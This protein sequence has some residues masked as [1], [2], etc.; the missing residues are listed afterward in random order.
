V[1]VPRTGGQGRQHQWHGAEQPFEHRDAVRSAEWYVTIQ[2]QILN[3]YRA[4]CDHDATNQKKKVLMA[5]PNWNEGFYYDGSPP[6][7]GLKLARRKL[8]KPSRAPYSYRSVA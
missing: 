1:D 6:H 4:N 2:I 5:D 3:R 7:T 8:P